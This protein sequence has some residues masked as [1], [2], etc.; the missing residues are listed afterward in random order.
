MAPGK[1]N[2]KKTVTKSPAAAKSARAPRNATEKPKVQAVSASR[3]T[4]AP[5]PEEIARV[6][7]NRYRQ[8]GGV[9]GQAMEDWLAAE[10]ELVS[11]K[12]LAEQPAGLSGSR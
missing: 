7:Y 10:A 5:T 3:A 11:G 4:R 9:P 8:R 12:A 6:A 2:G 1:S